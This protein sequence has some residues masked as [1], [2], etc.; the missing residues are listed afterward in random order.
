MADPVQVEDST[1]NNVV[2]EAATPFLVDFWA[3][4]CGP[5]R[6]IAPLVEELAGEY[7]GRIGFGKINVDENPKVAIEY[8][9][10]SMPTLL[11]F[12]DGK[13][14]TQIVGVRSKEELK[15]QLDASLA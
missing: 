7:E 2:V 12:K 6:A 8:G 4:W 1:F 5:C 14:M 11:I 3:P 15:K 13:P 9:V 10:R